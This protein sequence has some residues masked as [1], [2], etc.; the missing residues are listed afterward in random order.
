VRLLQL[1]TTSRSNMISPEEKRIGEYEKI[2][3]TA[4]YKFRKAAEYD[5]LYQEGTIAVWLCPP[6]ADPQYVSQ[7]VYNRLKNWI[8]FIKRLRHH[9]SVDYEEIVEGKVNNTI[10]GFDNYGV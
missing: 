1:A 3:A 9:H 2:I 8:R 10:L 7:A 5:D 4:A 6:D